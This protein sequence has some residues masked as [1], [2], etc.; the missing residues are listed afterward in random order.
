M[1]RIAMG[2]RNWKAVDS[3]QSHLYPATKVPLREIAR[4]ST[5]DDTPWTQSQIFQRP[6]HPHHLVEIAH[7]LPDE[8]PAAHEQ[9]RLV[10]QRNVHAA[11]DFV[12]HVVTWDADSQGPEGEFVRRLRKGEM[13]GVWC[14]ACFVGWTNVVKKVEVTLM[15]E[16]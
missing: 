1:V 15:T 16:W 5:E 6:E 14:R 8:P 12:E 3:L 10:V 2:V 13:V 11:R 4:T 7:P 9:K